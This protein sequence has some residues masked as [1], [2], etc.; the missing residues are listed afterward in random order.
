VSAVVGIAAGVSVAIV[1]VALLLVLLVGICKRSA[2]RKADQFI[3]IRESGALDGPDEAAVAVASAAAES[4]KAALSDAVADGSNAS[5]P[6][7]LSTASASAYTAASDDV[8]AENQHGVGALAVRDGA[9]S[10]PASA[11]ST[12]NDSVFSDPS[13]TAAANPR[14]AEAWVIHA[15]DLELGDIVGEGSFGVVRSGKW[16]GRTVAVKQI[17]RKA[18]DNDKALADFEAEVTRMSTLQPH[19]NVVQLYG[20]V[21]DLADGDIAAVMEWCAS[22]ALVT[23]LYGPKKR[24]DLA[25]EQ[26]LQWAYDASCGIMHLHANGI[27]H[28][29]VAARNVLLA[30]TREI[31]A[32]VSDF[33]MSRSLGGEG[34]A[35]YVPE[36]T[37]HNRVGP[38]AWMAPEQLARGAYSKASD[39]FAFACFLFEIYARTPPWHGVQLMQVAFDVMRGV[40]LP[41]PD[42]APLFV[43]ELAAQ[44][45]D[46]DSAK[47]PRMTDVCLILGSQTRR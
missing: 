43:R 30:G 10:P 5:M 16:R 2:A 47:R 13:D 31:T 44:C 1:V 34:D 7:M 35:T 36:T 6:A 17:K 29:D 24:N 45:F 14:R 21:S 41:F 42:S 39:V 19:E 18:F 46:T 11:Y 28:R 15:V 22:G 25:D 8:F 12:E 33:G 23:L 40:R 3:E 27:V 9:L 4:I 20:V 32:K 38:V 37:T 26:L